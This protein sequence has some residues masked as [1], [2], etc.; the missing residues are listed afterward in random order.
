M[1]PNEPSFL[2]VQIEV[3][4]VGGVYPME[5]HTSLLNPT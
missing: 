4:I 3:V 2:K 1:T 5:N